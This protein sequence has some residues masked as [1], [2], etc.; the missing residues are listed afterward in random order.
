MSKRPS[1]KTVEPVVIEYMKVYND[2]IVLYPSFEMFNTHRGQSSKSLDQLKKGQKIGSNGFLMD[3]G[4]TKIQKTVNIWVTAIVHYMRKNK[5]PQ[6]FRYRYITFCTLT[7]PAPQLHCDKTVKKCLT[8]WLKNMVKTYGLKSYLWVSELQK[9][10]NI[11]FHIL[12]G[13]PLNHNII[14]STW[15]SAINKIGYIDTFEKTH[16][17]RNAPTENIQT[18]RDI[19]SPSAYIIK[20]MEKASFVRNQCGRIWGCSSNLSRIEEYKDYSKFFIEDLNNFIKQSP[21]SLYNQEYFSI[22]NT[23]SVNK[24]TVESVFSAKNFEK[25]QNYYCKVFENIYN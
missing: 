10:G 14:R 17:H 7:L 2:K 5:I 9:N 18:L 25:I 23:Y 12:L 24:K 8:N 16:G 21:K 11:H 20:Y 1:S 13:M 3:K 15:N 6:K 19:N 22:I 4:K